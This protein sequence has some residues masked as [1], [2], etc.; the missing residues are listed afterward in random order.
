MPE[1]KHLCNM[2]ALSGQYNTKTILRFIF[3]KFSKLYRNFS[4]IPLPQ[5][6]RNV[7]KTISQETKRLAEYPYSKYTLPLTKY[8]HKEVESLAT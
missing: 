4:P 3:K 7:P 8:R 5:T 6:Q 2:Q 1:M